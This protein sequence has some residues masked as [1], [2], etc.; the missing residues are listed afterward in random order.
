MKNR[1]VLVMILLLLCTTL[2][3]T[4]AESWARDDATPYGDDLGGNYVK[5]SNIEGKLWIAGVAEGDLYVVL[6]SLGQTAYAPMDWF[7]EGNG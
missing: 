2:T 1:M 4:S 3:N 7:C 6:T 5:E